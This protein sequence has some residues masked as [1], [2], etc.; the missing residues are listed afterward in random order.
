MGANRSIAGEW[1]RRGFLKAVGATGAACWVGGIAKARAAQEATAKGRIMLGSGTHSYEWVVGWGE[2]PKDVTY[3]NTHGG[4][5]I[6]QKGTIYV[7]TDSERAVIM[8]DADGKF[9]GSW[10]KEFQGGLHGMAITKEG[11]QEVLYLTHTARHELVKA[12]LKGEVIWAAGYPEKSGVYQNAGQYNPTGVAV[13]PNGELY[14]GDGYGMHWVHHYSSKGEYLKSFGGPGTEPGKFN[15]P[16]GVW[17]DTRDATP[18]LLVAD[19]ANHRLQVFSLKGEYLAM[20]GDKDLRMPCGIHQH[21]TDL[22]VPDLE[23]RVTIFD[24]QNQLVTHLGDN[25]D[26]AKRKNNGVSREQWKDGD[27]IAPHSARFDTA[28]N[29][30]VMDWN[31]LGR[32][33]KLRRV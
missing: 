21:G 2:L 28:G 23:G 32:I 6:D 3:G 8:F 25:P 19:R 24:K 13:A 29:L 30:Y 31:F 9:L 1:T 33:T 4:I 20:I 12:T 18:Q 22:V 5:I 17:V 11:D 14:V 27:F 15:T 16:H 10:G 26:P 7:N